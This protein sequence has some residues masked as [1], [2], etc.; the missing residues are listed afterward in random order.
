MTRRQAGALL[1]LFV[2]ACAEKTRY[3][4]REPSRVVTRDGRGYDLDV[5]ARGAVVTRPVLVSKEELQQTL[6]RRAR[7]LHLTEPPPEAARRMLEAALEGEW[8][9][10]VHQGRVFTLVPANEK[11]SVAPLEDESLRR[12]YLRWCDGRG[13]GDCLS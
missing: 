12:E 8:L 4:P 7:E 3:M 9:A 10:E 13:G 1:L 6:R 5:V 11:T 2:T